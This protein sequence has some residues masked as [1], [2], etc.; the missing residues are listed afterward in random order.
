MKISVETY[1]GSIEV[2]TKGK[3]VI[4]RMLDTT[5]DLLAMTEMGS[6]SALALGSNLTM[7]GKLADK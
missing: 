1:H 4:V 7:A 5:G 3:G 6:D 2:A